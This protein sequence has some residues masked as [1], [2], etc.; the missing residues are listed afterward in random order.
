[1]FEK[2]MHT[3]AQS[4]GLLY[5]F[6]HSPINHSPF[7]LRLTAFSGEGDTRYEQ[8]VTDLGVGMVVKEEE[9]ERIILDRKSVV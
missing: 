2:F 6:F 8:R 3:L 9:L 7:C 4:A 5:S 1:M